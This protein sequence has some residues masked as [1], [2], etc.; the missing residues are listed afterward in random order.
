MNKKLIHLFVSVVA[1]TLF[2]CATPK[3]VSQLVEHTSVD[4][5]YLSNMQYD[6]IYIYKDRVID[7]MTDTVYLKE[8]SVEYRFKLS[9]DTIHII[10]RDSIPYEVTIIKT[11]EIQRPLTWYDHLCRAT[12]WLDIGFVLLVIIRLIKRNS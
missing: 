8:F 5:V 3:Q 9:R 10:Q 4:T 7:H 2:G 11:K 6:S 12:F 1:C